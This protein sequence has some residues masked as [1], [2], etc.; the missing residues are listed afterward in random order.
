MITFKEVGIKKKILKAIEELGFQI[1]MPVQEK[2]MPHLISNEK[3]LV[4]HEGIRLIYFIKKDFIGLIIG[5]HMVLPFQN[6]II[7]IIG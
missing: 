7:F 2:V 3:K 6:I 1:P 5:C 4:I